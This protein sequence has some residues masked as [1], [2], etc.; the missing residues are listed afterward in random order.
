[1]DM[2]TLKTR[3]DNQDLEDQINMLREEMGSMRSYICQLTDELGKQRTRPV[4]EPP[5]PPPPE[6]THTKLTPPTQ[7]YLKPLEKENSSEFFRKGMIRNTSSNETPIL[8]KNLKLSIENFS[9]PSC[10]DISSFEQLDAPISPTSNSN[11]LLDEEDTLEVL[12]V[13]NW[14]DGGK[15]S[16]TKRTSISADSIWE[17]TDSSIAT[18]CITSSAET[19]TLAPSSDFKGDR[20]QNRKL[21]KMLHQAQADS[22]VKHELMGRL[23]KTE[24]YYTQ[25]QSHYEDKLNQLRLHLTEVQ[26]ERDVA[27]KRRSV[28]PTMS[29]SIRE[30]P[31]SVL[32]LRENKQAEELRSE[33]QVKVKQLITE[34]HELRKKNAQLAQTHHT[35]QLKANA[36]IQQ[37]Q[38]DIETLSKRNKRQSRELKIESGGAKEASALHEKE[39]QQLKRREAAA[40]E[41]KKKTEEANEAQN[42][43]IK[44]RSEEV[45]SAN[46][47]MRQLVNLLRKS[48]N[49]G[50]FLNE[51]NLE[52]ILNGTFT[53]TPTNAPPRRSNRP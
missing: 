16:I 2:K 7:Q 17:D 10:Q 13:P 28:S 46:S 37:L 38:K 51:S 19:P 1:M 24:D 43:L 33:Y 8:E 27:L 6:I 53:P 21:L 41:A 42:Q 50:T 49:A 25:M 12:A 45:A 15:E 44:K 36:T 20:K 22:L 14:S 48:A 30:R 11:I 23:E 39:L 29:I 3:R 18:S 26:R 52:K 31:E 34:N 32:Q 4:I 47:H 35:A 40:L 9:F 5:S